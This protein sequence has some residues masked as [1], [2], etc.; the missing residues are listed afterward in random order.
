[1]KSVFFPD[2]VTLADIEYFLFS[3][4]QEEEDE[5]DELANNGDDFVSV[6]DRD[7]GGRKKRKKFVLPSQ[8]A[9]GNLASEVVWTGLTGRDYTAKQ[10]LELAADMRV[11]HNADAYREE[12]ARASASSDGGSSADEEADDE[13]EEEG[14]VRPYGLP[15]SD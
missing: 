11:E 15:A 1:M 3:K 13:E 10:L 7:G 6:P 14:E 9:D 8:M 5:E 2:E 12:A 4:K